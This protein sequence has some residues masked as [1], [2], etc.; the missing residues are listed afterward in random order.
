MQQILRY[1][2]INAA[3][4]LLRVTVH[5]WRPDEDG[6]GATVLLR[7]LSWSYY[8]RNRSEVGELKMYTLRTYI[9]LH[10]LYPRT[11]TARR[12]WNRPPTS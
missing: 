5:S 9:R 3:Q 6:A 12:E 1:G 4:I 7:L 10:T 8:C 2:S 11:G